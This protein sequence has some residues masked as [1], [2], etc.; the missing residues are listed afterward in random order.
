MMCDETNYHRLINVNKSYI[1][2]H[3]VNVITNP[4]YFHIHAATLIQY[5]II[6]CLDF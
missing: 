6:S 1:Q 3:L 4:I 2:R 5:T